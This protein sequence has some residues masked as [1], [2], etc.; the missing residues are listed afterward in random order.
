[1]TADHV[2]WATY[3]IARQT[4]RSCRFAQVTVEVDLSATS[5]ASV[6]AAGNDDWRREAELGALRAIGSI[7][8]LSGA[9][10]VTVTDILGTDIDTGVGD[11]YEATGNAVR[12][13][14]GL[15]A[16]RGGIG[17]SEVELVS[18]K[19]RAL[20]GRRLLDVVEARYWFKGRRG[21][22]SESLLHAWFQFED[23]QSLMVHGCGERLELSIGE[24]YG[25]YDM[26]EYGETRVAPARAPDLLAS[27]VGAR[28][29]D[30]AV[31]C[32]YSTE[33]MCGAVIFRF[34]AADLVIGT[35][36]DE[37]VL[38]AGSIPDAVLPYW[39]RPAW[40]G[41]DVAPP[42]DTER[43]VRRDRLRPHAPRPARRSPGVRH[44]HRHRSGQAVP[45]GRWGASPADSGVRHL[46][47]G[48]APATRRPGRPA[49]GRGGSRPARRRAHRTRS[50]GHR[51]VL[52][53]VAGGRVPRD[54]VGSG[55]PARGARLGR[56]LLR[57]RAAGRAEGR[58]MD[59]GH[60]TLA[61]ARA[62]R[63]LRVLS[64]VAVPRD[65]FFT[66]LLL[67]LPDRLGR[68]PETA[69]G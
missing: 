28:L 43:H 67:E 13:A 22:D 59:G 5:G 62:G 44:R 64:F 12:E 40:V 53:A 11:I 51:D 55:A 14:L 61:A 50:E 3:R 7:P 68:T 20:I 41:A 52:A 66:D 35:L 54:A 58:G 25:S 32:G 60:K 8:A 45:D 42:G 33:P 65:P 46:R 10:H 37:W 26:A 29:V 38:S 2:Q 63:A 48:A 24:P 19:L 69:G 36:G 30:A 39:S 15:P 34:D 31:I 47:A 27:V 23:L 18:A 4:A 1:M 21:P 6:T 9:G 17:V 57:P 49:V 16:W 56:G